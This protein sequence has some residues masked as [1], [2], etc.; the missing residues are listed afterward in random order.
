M[1]AV[2][3][4]D[5]PFFLALAAHHQHACILSRRRHRQRDQFGN[6]QAG[7][8]KHFEQAGEARRAQPFRRVALWIGGIG[9]RLLQQ[10]I[11]VGDG[12]DFR[13]RQRALGSFQHGS[14]IVAPMAFRVEETVELAN[15]RQPP[16][17]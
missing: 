17:H 8:V 12:E 11:D 6:A 1:A 5:E 10:T 9:M 14:G 4:R 13:Q 7:G 15:G 2:V 16:R 3:E